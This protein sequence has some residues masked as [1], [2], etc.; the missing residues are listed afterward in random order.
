MFIVYRYIVITVTSSPTTG[1]IITSEAFPSKTNIC[2]ILFIS[3]LFYLVIIVAITVP[4]V[5][6][7]IVIIIIII[8]VVVGVYKGESKF[9]FTLQYYYISVLR[10]I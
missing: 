2:S 6:L 3:L 9:I 5:V 8:A 7:V 1:G 10:K 4:S